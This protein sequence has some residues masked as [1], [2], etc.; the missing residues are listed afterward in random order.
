MS[1]RKA[2]GAGENH[3]PK[4]KKKAAPKTLKEKIGSILDTEESLTSLVALKKLLAERF[5]FEANDGNNKRLQAALQQMCDEGAAGKVGASYHGSQDSPS[6]LAHHQLQQQ[7][8]AEREQKLLHATEM[9]CP[10][11]EQWIDAY[12]NCINEDEIR[13]EEIL[14]R[15]FRCSLCNKEFY[16]GDQF[17]DDNG[18]VGRKVRFIKRT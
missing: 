1:K 18:V 8:E 7:L 15:I 3:E 16:S 5:G 17:G 11:C 6:F 9:C 14:I 12:T 4:P 10:W 13:S 2:D